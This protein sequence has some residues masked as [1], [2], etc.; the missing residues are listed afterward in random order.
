[1][2]DYAGTLGFGLAF[3]AASLAVGAGSAYLV[4]RSLLRQGPRRLVVMG[5]AGL[6]IS[7]ALGL[8]ACLLLLWALS[9]NAW[10]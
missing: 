10:R 8:F 1:M 5:V 7:L 4:R 2:A 3:F 6:L 9:P